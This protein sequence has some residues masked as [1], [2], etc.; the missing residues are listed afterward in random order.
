VRL[1]TEAAYCWFGRSTQQYGE[2]K[3][4]PHETRHATFL[5]PKNWSA[6]ILLERGNMYTRPSCRMDSVAHDVTG[7]PKSHVYD[8]S[9]D[10]ALAQTFPFPPILRLDRAFAPT[11]EDMW[12]L[13]MGESGRLNTTNDPLFCLTSRFSLNSI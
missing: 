8:L 12:P 6:G 1:R 11:P 3:E 13:K 9:C 7:Q 10:W 2:D 5:P 4:A